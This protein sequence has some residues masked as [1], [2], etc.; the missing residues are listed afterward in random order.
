MSL[1]R[2][3]LAKQAKRVR[4]VI[5]G[6]DGHAERQIPEWWSI[7]PKDVF[8]ARTDEWYGPRD[9]SPRKKRRGDKVL[10]EISADDVVSVVIDSPEGQ[11]IWTMDPFFMQATL[12]II[13]VSEY[14]KVSM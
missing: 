7:E 10:T 11:T 1:Q 5:Y 9:W 12:V 6:A 3:F 4:A 2:L 14:K 13:P 8:V